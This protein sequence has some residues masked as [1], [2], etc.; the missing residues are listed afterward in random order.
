MVMRQFESFG[1]LHSVNPMGIEVSS[2]LD[3]FVFIV[4]HVV[5]I[6]GSV[7]PQLHDCVSSIAIT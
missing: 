7:N 2:H 4:A 1:Y 5:L 3:V 6:V